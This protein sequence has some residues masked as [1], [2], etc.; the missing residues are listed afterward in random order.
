MGHNERTTNMDRII[1]V[2]IAIFAVAATGCRR[3][4]DIPGAAPKGRQQVALLTW[5]NYDGVKA[6]DANNA[7]YIFD[8]KPLGRG[9]KGFARVLQRVKALPPKT[10][11]YMYPDAFVVRDNLTF[12]GSRY[13]PPEFPD[14]VPFRKNQSQFAE[15][16]RTARESAITLWFLAGPPG[17][18]TLPDSIED[19]K[20]PVGDL[21]HGVGEE[22]E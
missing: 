1:K 11:L 22:K 15:L 14:T 3:A 16:N 19:V 4:D 20:N 9:K 12:P 10:E 8:G 6:V 2:A 17:T 5:S 21:S 7:A 18:L 13:E